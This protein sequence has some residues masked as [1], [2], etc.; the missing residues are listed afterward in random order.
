MLKISLL[1]LRDKSFKNDGI[2]FVA[3]LFNSVKQNRDKTILL[4]CG[5]NTQAHKWYSQHFIDE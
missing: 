1:Y 5:Q 4:I 2:Y 3:Y